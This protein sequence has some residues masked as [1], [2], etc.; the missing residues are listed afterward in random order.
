MDSLTIDIEEDPSVDRWSS[1]DSSISWD[2]WY[3]VT[4]STEQR[5]ATAIE[6]IELIAEQVSL[7]VQTRSRAAELYG[8]AA[9]ELETDGRPTEAV[10]AAIVHL[11]MREH[12]EPRPVSVLAEIVGRDESEITQL[13]R[14]L[15]RELQLKVPIPDPIEYLPYLQTALDFPDEVVEDAERCLQS[16]EGEAN[17][18]GGNPI[19]V[20]GAV[21]YLASDGER[22]QRE[23]AQAAGVTKETIRKRLNELRTLSPN[24]DGVPQSGVVSQ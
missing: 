4:N 13:A 16:L 3:R 1:D 24:L 9:L 10:V 5:V 11:S 23:V 15:Q 17:L 20:A 22:S 8:E 2:E 18:R 6:V 12:G 14:S 7:S 21:L 19:G